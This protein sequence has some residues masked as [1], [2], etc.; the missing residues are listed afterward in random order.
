[1]TYVPEMWVL[2][3][4]DWYT[5]QKGVGYVPTEKAPPE[6][7]AALKKLNEYDKKASV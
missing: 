5:T 6:A 2:T 1:M 4:L 7:V 3:H